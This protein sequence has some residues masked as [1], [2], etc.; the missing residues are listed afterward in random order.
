MVWLRGALIEYGS[1]FL[2]PLPNLVI[3][4]F[5]PT[6]LTR[7]IQ[8]PS[9][10]TG[11]GA[12]ELHQAG[13]P[14]TE[15]ISFTAEFSAADRL[16]DADPIATALGI[17]PALAALE[18]MAHPPA[19]GGLLAAALDAVGDLLGGNGDANEQP[20]PRE[21]YPRILFLWGLTRALPVT[22]E[23]M[24]ITEEQYDRLLNPVRA[25]VALSLAVNPLSA[26]DDDQVGQGALRYSLAAKEAMALLS[27]AGAAEA[28]VEIVSF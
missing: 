22:I 3:F 15:R 5:N 1:D 8:M 24:T 28:A 2:G 14:P 25:K 4:Q 6:T 16:N 18:Q 20:I 10:P 26:C 23:S 27:L 21:S 19:G 7:T 13:E 9:R 12:R 17:G 11:A